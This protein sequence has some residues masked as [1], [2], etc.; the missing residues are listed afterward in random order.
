MRH[1]FDKSLGIRCCG[2]LLYTD[3][4]LWFILSLL[5]LG[6]TSTHSLSLIEH[7]EAQR[8]N[9]S[10]GWQNIHRA[11]MFGLYASWSQRISPFFMNLL[12][13]SQNWWI[14]CEASSRWRPCLTKAMYTEDASWTFLAHTHV[15]LLNQKWIVKLAY[16]FLRKEPA[17]VQMDKRADGRS[18]KKV[19]EREWM[20]KLEEEM[21]RK[22][23]RKK[24]AE[25]GGVDRLQG[26]KG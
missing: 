9:Y 3:S 22:M 12:F 8:T 10:S 4:L 13:S 26:W 1:R 14:M 18:V 15:S 21:Q 24:E 11:Q 7:S 16:L 6:T 2:V 25:N 17:K 5:C 19:W 20:G 23:A